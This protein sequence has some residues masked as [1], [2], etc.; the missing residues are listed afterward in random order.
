MKEQI[1]AFADFPES[2]WRKVCSRS[3]LFAWTNRADEILA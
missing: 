3:H 1:T 2:H